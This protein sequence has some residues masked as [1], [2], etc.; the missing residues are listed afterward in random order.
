MIFPLMIQFVK[1]NPGNAAADK[2]IGPGT[3][4]AVAGAPKQPAPAMM[5]PSRGSLETGEL[6]HDNVG[7]G[8][9]PK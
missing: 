3:T 5:T 7:S 9:P 2:A 6:E 4:Q 8:L 1:K